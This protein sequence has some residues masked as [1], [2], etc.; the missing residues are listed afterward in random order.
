MARFLAQRPNHCQ[1]ETKMHYFLGFIPAI[2]Y[3]AS[4]DDSLYERESTSLEAV[5]VNVNPLCLVYT[6]YIFCLAKKVSNT[7][8]DRIPTRF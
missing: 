4:N 1:I 5:I 6:L 7:A 8:L 2:T 3:C